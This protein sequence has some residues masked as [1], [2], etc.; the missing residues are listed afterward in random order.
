MKKILAICSAL[1][2]LAA[3][4]VCAE[5]IGE[6]YFADDFENQTDWVS[7][8][9]TGWGSTNGGAVI[10]TDGK[11]GKCAAISNASWGS[12][13]NAP[14]PQN[15]SGIVGVSFDMMMNKRSVDGVYFHKQGE[16]V[17]L[18]YL[19]NFQWRNNAYEIYSYGADIYNTAPVFTLQ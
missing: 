1:V 10:I 5:K 7:L 13:L 9:G 19:L 12:S 11:D 3:N 2:M 15:L 17:P 8:A 16:N 4:S 14:V 18:E 6:S